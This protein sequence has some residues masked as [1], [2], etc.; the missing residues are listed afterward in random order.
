[1][2]KYSMVLQYSEEDRAF[3]VSVPE[4]PGCLA[5]GETPEKAV[6]NAQEVIDLWLEDAAGAGERPP[7][8]DSDR[9]YSGR[10]LLRLPRW[11]HRSL[12]RNAEAEGTSLNQH[13]VS[14]LAWA[15][16]AQAWT[17]SRPKAG[18]APVARERRP[19]RSG[20]SRPQQVRRAAARGR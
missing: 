10:I 2:N 14:L 8:P 20:S 11:L 17:R 15:Q 3:I 5:D 19:S 4:L 18:A 13:L 12:E 16:G 1:V 7:P 9:S 6:R